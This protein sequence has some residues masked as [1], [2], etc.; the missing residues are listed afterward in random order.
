MC[1]ESLTEFFWQRTYTRRKTKQ[2]L[3]NSRSVI[4]NEQGKK[5]FHWGIRTIILF[6]QNSVSNDTDDAVWSCPPVNLKDG[7]DLIKYFSTEITIKYLHQRYVELVY[8]LLNIFHLLQCNVVFN[9][10]GDLF[11]AKEIIIDVWQDP[12]S[13]PTAVV[14]MLTWQC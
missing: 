4:I 1:W 7:N 13:T 10:Y 8:F 9:I 6:F 5:N 12:K 14:V 3:T 11:Y 2:F